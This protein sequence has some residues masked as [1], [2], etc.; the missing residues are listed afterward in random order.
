MDKLP[1]DVRMVKEKNPRGNEICNA[2]CLLRIRRRL[3]NF[4]QERNLLKNYISTHQL[5]KAV[6]KL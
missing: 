1:T 6:E 2:P 5:L 4:N 3:I